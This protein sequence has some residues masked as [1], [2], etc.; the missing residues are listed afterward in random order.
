MR[1]TV[2]NEGDALKPIEATG[3]RAGPGREGKCEFGQ[4]WGVGI[5]LPPR[6]TVVMEAY[7]GTKKD[8]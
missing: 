1:V 2:V 8:L 4:R 6:K 3:E 7:P 5:P